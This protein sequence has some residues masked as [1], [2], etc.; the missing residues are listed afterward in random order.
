MNRAR[1]FLIAAAT[2]LLLASAGQLW[3]QE[4]APGTRVRV[5]STAPVKVAQE[6]VGSVTEGTEL[7]VLQREG[8]WVYVETGSVS[9]WVH[10]SRVRVVESP[11]DEGAPPP[12]SG[13][14]LLDRLASYMS[15]LGY[16]FLR[17]DEPG[18]RE[19]IILTGF[20]F[21]E[22][23]FSI[24][25]IIDPIVEKGCLL[26][27]APR[28]FFARPNEN[29]TPLLELLKAI[30]Y[31]N[32]TIIL[33][34]FCYDPRDGEVSFELNIAID[35]ISVSFKQFEHCLRVLCLE[36]KDKLPKLKAIWEGRCTAEALY[37]AGSILPVGPRG[38]VTTART[39]ATEA[40]VRRDDHIA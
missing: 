23:D 3:A 15:R 1:L 39:A 40:Y 33:G 36:V 9:G 37:Q 22:E 31:I 10:I 25:V 38:P 30:G 32:Y 18:E 8:N 28:L 4:I 6:V 29:P 21:V 20:T 12:P 2:G 5:I 26:M 16:R 14:K 17:V 7:V 13:D 34:K 35:D 19:G 24:E 11:E 27:K